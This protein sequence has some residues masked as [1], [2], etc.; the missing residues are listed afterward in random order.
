M[1]PKVVFEQMG[2]SF[3]PE[4]FKCWEFDFYNHVSNFQGSDLRNL[5]VQIKNRESF[6]SMAQAVQSDYL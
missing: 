6:A 3:S 4:Q 1:C 2:G 5:N